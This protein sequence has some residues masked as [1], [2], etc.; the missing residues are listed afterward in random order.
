MSIE[1][2]LTVGGALPCLEKT[3]ASAREGGTHPL[4]M[5]CA[6]LVTEARPV[7]YPSEKG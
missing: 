7:E 2:D 5:E 3:S 4:M 1:K 6:D